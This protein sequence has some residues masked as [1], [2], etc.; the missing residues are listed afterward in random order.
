MILGADTRETAGNTVCSPNCWK[1][2]KMASNIHCCG[3]GTAADT[4]HTTDQIAANLELH[5][6]DTGREV[7]VVTALTMLQQ[8]LFRYQGHVSAALVLGG[9]DVTGKHLFMVHPHG[10]SAAL[11]YATMGSGSLAAMAVFEQKY[12]KD[13]NEQTAKDLVHEAIRSGIFHDLGSGSNVDLCIIRQDGTGDFLRNY[14]K[15]NTADLHGEKIVMPKGTTTVLTKKTRTHER[16]VAA[17][18]TAV[19]V[20]EQ[21]REHDAMDE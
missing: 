18:V 15:T 2:H 19:I 4:E 8:H 17:N 21:K 7:R 11:N 9:C 10:S 6:L 12:V 14:D 3:A 16:G 5:R 1:I 13:M 20:S